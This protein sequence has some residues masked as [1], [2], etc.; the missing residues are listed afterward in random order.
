MKH[1]LDIARLSATILARLAWWAVQ[2][3]D[4][5]LAT[6]LL[7]IALILVVEWVAAPGSVPSNCSYVFRTQGTPHHELG[8][9]Y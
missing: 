6:A 2:V 4:A 3:E 1:H 7:L 9:P 5:I 8:G